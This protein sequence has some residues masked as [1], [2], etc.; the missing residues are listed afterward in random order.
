MESQ[1]TVQP[2]VGEAA[3]DPL[4]IER[5]KFVTDR[6]KYFTD[7]ARD[8]FGSYSKLL[9]GL[10]AGAMTLVSTRN[11]LELRPDVV[12]YLVHGIVYLVGFFGVVAAAQIIFCL[13]RWFGYRRAQQALDPKAPAMGWWW[14]IFETLYVVAIVVSI[15]ALWH[16]AGQLPTLIQQQPAV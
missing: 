8:A 6:Q 1:A 13:A 11:R 12:L 15:W 5:Y 4:R 9:A 3:N 10:T 7:L 16:I 2:T 14:W